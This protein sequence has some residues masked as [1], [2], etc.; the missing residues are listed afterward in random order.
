MT[1]DI[2]RY[3]GTD[4]TGACRGEVL[5]SRLQ[6]VLEHIRTR[7]VSICRGRE[8]MTGYSYGEFYDWDLYFETLFLSYFGVS[9]FCRN[10]VE[11]FLDTQEPSGFVART[12]M[13]PRQRQHFKPFLAQTA[14]LG[15]L[16]T[17]DCRWLEGKYWARLKRYLHYWFWHCDADKNGLCYWDSADHSG[18]DN[19]CLRAGEIGTKDVEGVD[20]N[21]YLVQELDAMGHLGELLGY[22]EE[23]AHF[24]EHAQQLRAKIEEIFWDEA[25]G[26]YYDRSEERGELIRVKTISGLMPLWCGAAS[27]ERAKRLVQEHLMNPREFWLEYPVATWAKNEKGY[28]QQ[29]KGGECNWMGCTWIPTNYMLFHGLMEYGFKKEAGV[30]ARKTYEL[31]ISESTTREY[32]NAENGCG[33]GLSPFWGWSTLGY[34]MPMEWTIGYNPMDHNRREFFTLAGFSANL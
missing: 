7:G 10:N 15:C 13:E 25:D 34:L 14:L 27:P 11:M 1:L 26:F 17:G 19:Q 16:Q 3:A 2:S 18:M 31:V 22:K 28:Y 24:F 30:L 33:Q 20:L 32:Y 8:V 5:E 4:R 6:E 9:K 29:R 23:A 21:C 12:I